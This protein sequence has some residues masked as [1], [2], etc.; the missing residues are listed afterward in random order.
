MDR[1]EIGPA[2]LREIERERLIALGAAAEPA[3]PEQQAA[4]RIR[5]E[6]LDRCDHRLLEGRVQKP[7][8]GKTSRGRLDDL[9]LVAGLLDLDVEPRSGPR[10]DRGPPRAAAARCGSG[11]SGRRRSA[12]PPGTPRRDA[13]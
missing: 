11:E 13:L 4:A 6:T 10:R 7:L 9:G 2:S 8:P 12:S 5:V 3:R 1:E